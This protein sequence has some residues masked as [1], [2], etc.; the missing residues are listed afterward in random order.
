MGIRRPGQLSAWLPEVPLRLTRRSVLRTGALAAMS[1]W[2]GA[3]L[4]SA[5]PAAR[6]APGCS[7]DTVCR[8]PAS[9]NMR[10][11]SGISTTSIRRRRRAGRCA[12]RRSARSTT[13]TRW[14]PGLKGLFAAA[15]GTICDTLMVSSLD[16]ADGQ[17]RADRRRGRSFPEL[18]NHLLSPARGRPPSRWHPDHGRGRDLFLRG[19]QENQSL[20]RRLLSRRRE[21]GEERRARGHLQGRVPRQP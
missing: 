1:P 20:H 13:S 3:V 2:S 18:Y 16:E 5:T 19:I 4:W 12:W 7:G 17:L 8:C 11:A 6:R 15:A 21:S 9:S 14:S 10:P